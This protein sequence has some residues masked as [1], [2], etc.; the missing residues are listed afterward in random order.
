MVGTVRQVV[1]AK[2]YVGKVADAC[3]IWI[4]GMY[5]GDVQVMVGP[6]VFMLP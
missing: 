4:G 6:A 3:R 1:S 5:Y 2:E